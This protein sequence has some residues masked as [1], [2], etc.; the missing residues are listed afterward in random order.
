MSEQRSGRRDNRST[1]EP[2]K[3]K[4]YVKSIWRTVWSAFQYQNQIRYVK[5]NIK[6]FFS[7]KRDETVSCAWPVI[8]QRDERGKSCERERTATA[9]RYGN[10][11]APREKALQRMTLPKL[12]RRRHCTAA[13]VFAVRPAIGIT[14]L[15]ERVPRRRRRWVV[16]N[17]LAVFRRRFLFL[18][19]WA[20]SYNNNNN[21]NKLRL[22]V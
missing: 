8:A 5:K 9:K 20:P 21:H 3:K 11:A 22:I 10:A 13:S 14:E 17:P 2:R 7:R 15:G 12:F 1:D 6:R 16:R 19:K 18:P 4:T